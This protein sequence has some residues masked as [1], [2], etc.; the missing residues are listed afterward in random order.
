MLRPCAAKA[1]R[2]TGR[3]RVLDI[4]QPWYAQSYAGDRHVRQHGVEAVIA[5]FAADF[6]GADGR[7]AGEPEIHNP[8]TVAIHGLAAVFVLAV[9]YKNPVGQGV[10]GV[11]KRVDYCALVREVV[12][13]VGFNIQYDGNLRVKL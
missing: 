11:L 10:Q 13:M 6:L 8:A 4:M 7:F 5:V 2:R 12:G 1:C 3:K 9:I